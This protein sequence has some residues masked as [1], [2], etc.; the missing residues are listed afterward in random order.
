[1]GESL[2]PNE[3]IDRRPWSERRSNTAIWVGV[4]VLTVG[5]FMLT[6]D[7]GLHWFRW[8]FNWWALLVLVPAAIVLRNAYVAY[9]AN[10]NQ[11]TRTIRTQLITGIALIAITPMFLFN[12]GTGLLWPLVLI[13]LCALMLFNVNNR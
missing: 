5:F 9:E 13:V 6:D 10:G 11:F 8:N 2:P 12:L 3:R 1:M 4:A 7:L